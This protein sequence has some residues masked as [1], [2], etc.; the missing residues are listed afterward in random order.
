MNPLIFSPTRVI[1]KPQRHEISCRSYIYLSLVLH[2]IQQ[3]EML[4]LLYE[5]Y[6]AITLG[7]VY[8]ETYMH[9]TSRAIK[10]ILLNAAVCLI[11][12]IPFLVPFSWTLHPS[13]GGYVPAGDFN[14]LE[15]WAPRVFSS[16]LNYILPQLSAIVLN[17]LIVRKIWL[18]GSIPQLFL[19]ASLN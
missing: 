17:F 4:L 11:L 7:Q 2:Q 8:K 6:Q 14:L 10:R 1:I 18:V 16:L 12:G 5:R 13:C 15:Y 3:N 19:L 9:D